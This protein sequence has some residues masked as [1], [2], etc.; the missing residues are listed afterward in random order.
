MKKKLSIIAAI[1]V[2]II[3]FIS[4]N[5]R[6]ES[7][8]AG[9]R[10][11]GF[12]LPVTGNAAAYGEA[13]Q[14]AGKLAIEDLKKDGIDID[15][16]FEDDQASGSIASGIIQKYIDRGDVGA[17]ISFGSG[18]ALALCKVIK[19]NDL[20]LFNSGSSPEI[21][22]C[23]QTFR[24]YPS[25]IYQGKVLADKAKELGYSKVALVY[26]NNDYGVGLKTEFLK[27][28]P[29][30][31]IEEMQALGATDFRTQ[32]LKIKASGAEQIV[33]IS[34]PAEAVPF[35]N[36]SV[37]QGLAMPILVS[38][39][40][41]DD[42]FPPLVS[43]TIHDKILAI[44]A[45]EYQGPE[46]AAYKKSYEEK[47]GVKPAAFSDYVYDNTIIA[48]KAIKNCS[49]D[50]TEKT[51]YEACME[52]FVKNYKGVGATGNISFNEDGDVL[53]KSYDTFVIKDGKF[54]QK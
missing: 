2:V 7:S 30:V 8:N 15:P 39:S 22:K 37:E 54:V 27:N 10:K 46:A 52:N 41:K 51:S 6:P 18:D 21:T 19:G 20:I 36:Q 9:L 14:N 44:A 38:E 23:D 13:A 31:V 35:L 32:I 49:S 53:G 50:S 33:L 12:I 48:G 11:I 28:Y 1:L 29:S 16:I 40:L 25:D 24:N 17:V 45:A 34:Q 42:S 3:I 4:L 43:K 5:S 26:L 47:Y